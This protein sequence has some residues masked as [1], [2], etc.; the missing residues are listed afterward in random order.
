MAKGLGGADDNKVKCA[1]D[2]GLSK[3]LFQHEL[4]DLAP[5]RCHAGLCLCDCFHPS[6]HAGGLQAGAARQIARLH[7][8]IP[9]SSRRSPSTAGLTP[10]SRLTIG[11]EFSPPRNVAEPEH[12]PTKSEKMYTKE[13]ASI[14]AVTLLRPASQFGECA[15][16]SL[17]E[18]RPSC[19]A[20]QFF[21][22]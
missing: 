4:A 20:S 14:S 7:P 2:P 5:C 1:P 8:L 6:C 16:G 15:L 18:L 17:H 13:D 21:P 9:C 19:P 3:P 11:L 12:F 22:M 10:P